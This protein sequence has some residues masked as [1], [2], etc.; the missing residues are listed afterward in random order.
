M[1]IF[2]E[3][4]ADSWY[5]PIHTGVEVE[6]DFVDFDKMITLKSYLVCWIQFWRQHGVEVEFDFNILSD[7]LMPVWTSH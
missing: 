2:D 1:N 7:T 3:T 6:F 5:C 4:S